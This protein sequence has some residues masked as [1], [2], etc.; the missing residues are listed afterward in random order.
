MRAIDRTILIDKLNLS[1]E[2]RLQTVARAFYALAIVCLMSVGNAHAI[3]MFRT[4]PLPDDGHG[5]SAMAAMQGVSSETVK[6][7][8]G[9][10][11]NASGMKVPVIWTV[12]LT[13]NDAVGL[14]LPLPSGQEGEAV[15]GATFPSGDRVVVGNL[16]EGLKHWG[17]IWRRPAM[18]AWSMP[19][20]LCQDSEQSWVTSLVYSGETGGLNIVG[21]TGSALEGGRWLAALHFIS[22]D[23]VMT[24][25]IPTPPVSNAAALRMRFD[26]TGAAGASSLIVHDNPLIAVSTAVAGGWL[27]DRQGRRRPVIWTNDGQGWATFPSDFSG[28]NQGQVND[29]H[30]SQSGWTVCGVN[31]RADRMLGF[32]GMLDIGGHEESHGLLQPLQGFASS[33][34][35]DLSTDGGA[36]FGI[37]TNATGDALAT[38]WIGDLAFPAQ[39]LMHDGNT[40]NRLESFR[41][42]DVSVATGTAV[43]APGGQPQA[44][45]FAPLNSH[46]PDT[47]NVTI[48]NVANNQANLLWHNDDRNLRARS[49]RV[50]GMQKALLDIGFTPLRNR[51]VP[52]LLQYNL[53]A[54]A[55]GNQPGASGTL[56]VYVLDPVSLKWPLVGSFNLTNADQACTG[57]FPGAGFVNTQTGNVRL[58]IEF[59]ADGNRPTT[60]VC[61]VATLV[62]NN[63]NSGK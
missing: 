43:V 49:E 57:Q 9:S 6:Q 56:N 7:V 30:A 3:E 50:G 5:S 28:G 2:H 8:V 29:V 23:S 32:N 12:N 40:V 21:A 48:G 52:D 20:L 15:G 44:C 37:S 17:V 1:T 58:W 13:T 27:T 25:D 24:I 19:E 36:T 34:A 51:G 18:G 47:I 26:I 16:I 35:I 54:R 59:I 41:I 14:E 11:M 46:V 62:D 63:S 4:V 33:N 39:Q 42:D 53:I 22:P 60:L 55:E 10:K 38:G 31:F 45:L 61:D